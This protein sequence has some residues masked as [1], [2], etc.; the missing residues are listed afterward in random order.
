MQTWI[1]QRAL[2]VMLTN[3]GTGSNSCREFELRR[4]RSMSNVGLDQMRNACKQLDRLHVDGSSRIAPG[5]VKSSP[6]SSIGQ[7]S[8]ISDWG[9][10]DVR[11]AVLFAVEVG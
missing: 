2:E 9:E 8:S 11:S 10:H 7:P 5:T 4:F 6:M 3:T 1:A